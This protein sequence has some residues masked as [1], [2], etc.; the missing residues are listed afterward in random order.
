LIC[1]DQQLVAVPGIQKSDFEAC[2]LLDIDGKRFIHVKKSSR[3]SSVL[4]HFFKQ[5]SNSAQQFRRFPA[6]WG[7]LGALVTAIKTKTEAKKLTKAKD[8]PGWQVEFWIA[9]APRADGSLN[10]PFFSKISLRDEAIKLKAM[11]FEVGLRFIS[12]VPDP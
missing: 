4:S 6:L 10:I 9:D 7:E 5:G 1:L 8:E 11:G 2:D 12:V 3:R